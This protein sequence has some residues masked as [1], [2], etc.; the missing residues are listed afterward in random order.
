MAKKPVRRNYDIDF[1]RNS[2][3]LS[4]E[5]DRNAKNVVGIPVPLMYNWRRDP[6]LNG[7]ENLP[8]SA[9]PSLSKERM[10]IRMLEKELL[11]VKMERDILKKAVGIFTP[12]PSKDTSL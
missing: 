1:Q 12:K 11:D 6:T 8:D 10:R 5:P 4:F 2:V 9:P 3:S 7:D